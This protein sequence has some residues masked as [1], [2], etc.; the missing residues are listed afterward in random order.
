MK[1]FKPNE[2]RCVQYFDSNA[3]PIAFTNKE[4]GSKDI[5]YLAEEFDRLGLQ[6][7]VV[8]QNGQPDAVSYEKMGIYLLEVIKSLKA[9]VD[10]LKQK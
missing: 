1:I 10:Q 8:Y 6:D 5:G 3:Q 9:E 4:T 2:C 7:L